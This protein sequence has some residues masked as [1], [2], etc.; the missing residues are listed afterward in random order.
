M[1]NRLSF[2]LAQTSWSFMSNWVLTLMGIEVT[3]WVYLVIGLVAAALIPV[4]LII[5]SKGT[6]NLPILNAKALIWPVFVTVVIVIGV[7]SGIPAT[8]NT[9]NDWRHRT[10]RVFEHA[11]MSEQE[12]EVARAECR[13][14]SLQISMFDRYDYEQNCLKAKGFRYLKLEASRGE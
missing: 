11:D 9:V 13:M 5:E 3:H 2:T 4:A 14:D 1:R 6:I 8:V 12:Q 7:T 10:I